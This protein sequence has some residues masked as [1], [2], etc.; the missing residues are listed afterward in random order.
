M[1]PSTPA[2]WRSLAIAAPRIWPST[3]VTVSASAISRITWLIPTPHRLTVYASAA[4]L[5]DAPATLV[6]GWLAR[7]YPSGTFPRRIA[8]T[9]PSARRLRRNPHEHERHGCAIG[10]RPNRTPALHFECSICWLPIA[11]V[12]GCCLL[13]QNPKWAYRPALVCEAMAHE[14]TNRA[15][16]HISRR[17]PQLHAASWFVV[18]RTGNVERIGYDRVAERLAAPSPSPIEQTRY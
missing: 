11:I 1:W 6:I 18:R 17:C 10:Q 15:P 4:P 5:P 16:W 3:A 8:L 12:Q 13:S 9:S 14:D 2:E 7:P